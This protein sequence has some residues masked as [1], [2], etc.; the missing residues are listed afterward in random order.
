MNRRIRV[1]AA[2]LAL[3]ALSAYFAESVVAASCLPGSGS[4]HERIVGDGADLAAHGGMHHA[5]VAPSE[6]TPDPR[7]EAPACPLGMTGAGSSCVAAS[8][9]GAA[10]AVRPLTATVRSVP[11]LSDQSRDRL[12]VSAHFRPPRS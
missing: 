2:L 9:P 6:G 7:P 1:L 12:L 8:L 5:P 10:D 4:G 3:F 11:L